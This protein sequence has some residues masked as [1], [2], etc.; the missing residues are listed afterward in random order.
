MAPDTQ[1]VLSKARLPP[2]WSEVLALDPELHSQLLCR[3]ILPLP[4][5]SLVLAFPTL[6]GLSPGVNPNHP[7]S[8]RF[9]PCPATALLGNGDL[10][11]GM[12]LHSR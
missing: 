12:G 1:K 3:S 7:P 10:L 5:T 11:G 8:F 2:F 9:L 4:H 6:P